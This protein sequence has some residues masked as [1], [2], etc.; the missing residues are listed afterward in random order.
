M[1]PAQPGNDFCG[2]TTFDRHS[3][4]GENVSAE[5]LSHVTATNLHG[6]FAT[7]TPALAALTA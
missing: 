3:P 2:I 4:D 7:F 6:A 1:R 5:T